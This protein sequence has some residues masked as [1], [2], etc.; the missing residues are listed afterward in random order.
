MSLSTD[1]P[2]GRFV[3]LSHLHRS[4]IIENN[5]GSASEKPK[6]TVSKPVVAESPISDV[7]EHRGP[8]PSEKSWA[9]KTLAPTLEK[10]PEKPIGATTGTNV[11]ERGHARF[12]TI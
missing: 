2:L 6:S 3:T 8:S 10:A 12:S 5:M 1:L 9:E 11:D 7:F 4:S